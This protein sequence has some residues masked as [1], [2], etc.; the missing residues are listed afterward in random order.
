MPWYVRY[1]VKS[2]GRR[3]ALKRAFP[4]RKAAETWVVAQNWRGG[5]RIVT[6]TK[7]KPGR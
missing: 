7:Q 5:S 4:T 6:V 3:V 1:R 2:S